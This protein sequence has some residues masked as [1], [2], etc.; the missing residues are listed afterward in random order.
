MQPVVLVVTVAAHQTVQLELPIQE[1]VAVAVIR[2]VGKAA[3]AAPV[4]SLSK[5]RTITLPHSLVVSHLLSQLLLRVST[6]TR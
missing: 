6:S 5:S 2:Q 3:T 1:M 4:S